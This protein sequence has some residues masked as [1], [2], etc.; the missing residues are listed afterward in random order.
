MAKSEKKKAPKSNGKLSVHDS[1]ADVTKTSGDPGDPKIKNPRRMN[2]FIIYFQVTIDGK[3]IKTGT[4]GSRSRTMDYKPQIVKRTIE[5][6]YRKKI[7]H[8]NSIS[9]IILD[10]KL[11]SREDY[12]RAAKDF[13]DIK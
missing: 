11:V 3:E 1:S 9:V 4:I 2:H 10:N 8:A 13:M 6:Q 12:I 5:D 7:P